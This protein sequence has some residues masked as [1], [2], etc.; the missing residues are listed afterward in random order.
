MPHENAPCGRRA[1]CRFRQSGSG[2]SSEKRLLQDGKRPEEHALLE[3][4]LRMPQDAGKT[5]DGRADPSQNLGKERIL[6]HGQW[7][8]EYA[9]MERTL[10]LSALTKRSPAVAGLF[11]LCPDAPLDATETRPGSE[12]GLLLSLPGYLP[13]SVSLMPPIVF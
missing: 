13:R 7:P 10:R 1:D 4:A 3:R 8:A 12:P 9:V 2:R 5:G 11:S 6:P